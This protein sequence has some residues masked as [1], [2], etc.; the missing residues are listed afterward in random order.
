MLKLKTQLIISF[1]L[2]FAWLFA[3][4]ANAEEVY[5]LPLAQKYNSEKPAHLI[6]ENETWYAKNFT[7]ED[8]KLIGRNGITNVFDF[9]G[10]IMG[11]TCANDDY[12]II[13]AHNGE[14]GADEG[15]DLWEWN[16]INNSR[17]EFESAST[18]GVLVED[19]TIT[20]DVSGSLAVIWSDAVVMSGSY[21]GGDASGYFYAVSQTGEFGDSGAKEAIS[22]YSYSAYCTLTANTFSMVNLCANSHHISEVPTSTFDSD[23]NFYFTNHY[24]DVVGTVTIA[25]NGANHI[26]K[27]IHSDQSLSGIY[28]TSQ[29]R[30]LDNLMGTTLDNY[31][32]AKYP[33]SFYNALYLGNITHDYSTGLEDPTAVVWSEIDD[34]SDFSVTEYYQQRSE[35]GT[36]I[37]GLHVLGDS[38][39]A[40]K[41]DQVWEI[42]AYDNFRRITSK[43]GATN[44]EGTI[45]SQG[46][47]VNYYGRI[48]N[49]LDGTW[50][51]QPIN[52]SLAS[53]AAGD[54]NIHAVEDK[55][56]DEFMFTAGTYMYIYNKQAQSFQMYQF[57][58]P[59]EVLSNSNPGGPWERWL[60]NFEDYDTLSFAEIDTISPY[61]LKGGAEGESLLVMNFFSFDGWYD[62]KTDIEYIYHTRVDSCGDL[63]K[64]KRFQ[65]VLLQ[66]LPST[67][68][69]TIYGWFSDSPL[70]N[71]S[72]SNLGT[73]TLDALGYGELWIDERAIWCTL[74]IKYTGADSIEIGK[75]GVKF[76]YSSH[77]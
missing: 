40:T 62:D 55:H 19:A 48:L 32:W 41:E 30:H 9:N 24:D 76:E 34:A 68:P 25:T 75:I 65:T 44:S 2:L 3:S 36:V 46:L 49:A 18:A 5:Y 66:G 10:E 45:A 37:T 54:W 70:G 51:S 69:F 4:F 11:F 31:V 28:E 1:W 61:I 26:Q 47:W 73:I 38:L 27:Y 60:P 35:E 6:G 8:G 33:A 7:F 23:S 59:V 17:Y 12:A 20:G 43:I 53:A 64:K 77:R 42:Q 50:L 14:T 56:N 74:K 72:Y 57:D 29:E 21:A 15:V 16:Y 71:I 39:F 67:G 13:A 22:A 63:T 58:Y 52:T